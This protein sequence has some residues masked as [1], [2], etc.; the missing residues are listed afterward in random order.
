MKVTESRVHVGDVGTELRAQVFDADGVS[1]VD[2]TGAQVLQFKL[3]K[4]DGSVIARSAEPGSTRKPELTAAQG[5]MHYLV[6]EDDLDQD[7]TWYITP[8]VQLDPSA[9]WHATGFDLLVWPH[10]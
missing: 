8:Y 3:R 9:K 7:G 1:V 2:L 10:D 6:L 4:P 5:W